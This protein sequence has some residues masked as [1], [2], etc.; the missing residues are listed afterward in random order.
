MFIGFG[1]GLR[2]GAG[3]RMEWRVSWPVGL[4][5]I[6]H[7]NDGTEPPALP[8]LCYAPGAMA[9]LSA[10]STQIAEAKKKTREKKGTEAAADET[11]AA[12]SNRTP[13][14]RAGP[15]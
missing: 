8:P 9:A 3:T 10:T 2:I 6:R 5:S 11:G 12:R 15:N 7:L 13:G 14:E 4:D 1:R